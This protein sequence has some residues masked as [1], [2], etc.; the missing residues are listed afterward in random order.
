M[1]PNFTFHIFIL[2]CGVAAVRRLLETRSRES[3]KV[4]RQEITFSANAVF[5]TCIYVYVLFFVFCFSMKT[6]SRACYEQSEHTTSRGEHHSWVQP[7]HQRQDAGEEGKKIPHFSSTVEA[8]TLHGGTTCGGHGGQSDAR[9]GCPGGVRVP[10]THPHLTPPPH[11]TPPW[12]DPQQW[13]GGRGGHLL[14]PHGK[15][16][17]LFFTAGTRGWARGEGGQVMP[18]REGGHAVLAALGG[19]ESE[20][21]PTDLLSRC[22]QLKN[23]SYG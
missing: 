13:R 22:P 12:S 8:L 20:G 2:H 5:Y 6:H 4:W 9:R 10:A 17:A 23:N 16:N 1:F 21:H 15:N 7:I 14:G 11:Q 18:V 3:D 19:S